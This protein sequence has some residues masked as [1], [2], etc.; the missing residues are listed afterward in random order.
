MT[1]AYPTSDEFVRH[2]KRVL[3]IWDMFGRDLS[4][5]KVCINIKRIKLGSLPL[6]NDEELSKWAYER[7]QRKDKILNQMHTE[8]K[9]K[10]N[11]YMEERRVLS[12]E[13]LKNQPK[14]KPSSFYRFPGE[15]IQDEPFNIVWWGSAWEGNTEHDTK[16]KK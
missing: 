12:S 10:L 16:K 8:A 3:T 15:P 13:F 9:S 2:G 6:S 7:F 14:P 11:K 1:I 5:S 4:Q